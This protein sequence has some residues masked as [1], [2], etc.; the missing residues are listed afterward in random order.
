MKFFRTRTAKGIYHEKQ[1]MIDSV[2]SKYDM[3]KR[4]EALNAYNEL[5]EKGIRKIFIRDITHEWRI[6]NKR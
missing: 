2:F 3:T 4:E 5:L 6:K 1:A